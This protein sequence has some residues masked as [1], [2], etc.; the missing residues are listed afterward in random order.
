MPQPPI[1]DILA[2]IVAAFSPRRV[3]LFGSRARGTAR[4]DSDVDLLIVMETPLPFYERIRS[5]LRLFGVR[6]WSM[7]V[8]VLTPDEAA[9]QRTQRN[10]II[11]RAEREGEVLY[12]QP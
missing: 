6:P 12:E 7:D 8:I 10:S 4:P 1:Q 5:V 2:T 3:V 9:A 11:A